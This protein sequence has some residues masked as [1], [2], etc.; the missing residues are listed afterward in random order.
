[1]RGAVFLKRS[2]FAPCICCRFLSAAPPETSWTALCFDVRG[3]HKLVQ[4][5]EDEQCFSCFVFATSGT[6]ATV[7]RLPLG[8][9]LVL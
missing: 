4:V 6:A 5:R 9:V 3:A 8:G 7:L 1:M 2:A